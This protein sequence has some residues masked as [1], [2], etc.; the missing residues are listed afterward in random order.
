[1]R[2]ERTREKGL[3]GAG[4]SGGGGVE[5]EGEDKVHGV[6]TDNDEGDSSLGVGS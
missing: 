4:Y 5:E 1:M 3:S 2:G 6:S